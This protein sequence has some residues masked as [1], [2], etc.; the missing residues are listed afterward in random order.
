MGEK[1]DEAKRRI[2]EEALAELLGRMDAEQQRQLAE[3]LEGIPEGPERDH[4]AAVGAEWL[5][6]Q[7]TNPLPTWDVP[8]YNLWW[9]E[10]D[11]K[12]IP[13]HEHGLRSMIEMES[14]TLREKRRVGED[15]LPDGRLLS[16]VFLNIDHGHSFL[17]PDDYRPM[18]YETMLFAAPRERTPEEAK[19]FSGPVKYDDL[20]MWRYHTREA[21]EIGHRRVLEALKSG[22]SVEALRELEIDP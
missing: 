15:E 12:A 1:L 20:A 7:K 9:R 6:R 4:F 8:G 10:E 14:P 19:Y 17:H 11:G 21:A 22:A 13:D 16:T 3:A 18:L 2:A 5:E